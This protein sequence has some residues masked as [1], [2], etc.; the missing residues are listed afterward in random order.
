[1]SYKAVINLSI[2]CCLACLIITLP[3]PLLAES[4]ATIYDKDWQVKEYLRER[5]GAS[6]ADR[7]IEIF[8]KDWTRKGYI[9]K[10]GDAYAIYDKNWERQGYIKGLEDYG[11]EK[12]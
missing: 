8:N 11:K 3:Y 2:W 7:T 4:T 1:M 12:R 6:E 9:R 10:E 5:E